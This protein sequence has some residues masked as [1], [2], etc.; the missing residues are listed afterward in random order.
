MQHL[1][2]GSSYFYKFMYVCSVYFFDLN[3]TP[4]RLVFSLDK[5]LFLNRGVF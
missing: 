3:N 1:D 4:I 5:S 2:V